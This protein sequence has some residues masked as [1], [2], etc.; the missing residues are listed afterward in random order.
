MVVKLSSNTNCIEMHLPADAYE[1]Q[2]ALDKLRLY[3]SSEVDCHIEKCNYLEELDGMDFK[4]DIFKINAFAQRIEFDH[5]DAE[6]QRAMIAAMLTADGNRSL[7]TLLK[8]TFTTNLTVFPCKDYMDYG[9][10]VI[11]NNLLDD[12]SDIPDKAIPYIDTYEVGKE[13]AEREHGIFAGG[14]YC[15]PDVDAVEELEITIQKPVESFFCLTLAPRGTDPD[16]TGEKYYLPQDAGR[17]A[18][19]AHDIGVDIGDLEIVGFKSALPRAEPPATTDIQNVYIYQALANK[20]RDHLTH[21]GVV[22][23]KAVMESKPP[24]SAGEIV[25][26]IDKVHRYNFDNKVFTLNDYGYKYLTG[27][28]PGNCNMDMFSSCRLSDIGEK[29]CEE[30]NCHVTDYGAISNIDQKLYSMVTI[31]DQTDD[32]EYYNSSDKQLTE[33]DIGM[34]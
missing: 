16:K 11:E 23:L 4:D 14:F 18:E 25:D 28:V 10:Y 29:L 7:D 30:K 27:I 5:P 15:I 8:V 17:I 19:Y 34:G 21:I 6:I 20:L 26:L 13:M 1:L 3:N 12:I 9:E 31:Q 22:I 33:E 2:D 32:E 24:M